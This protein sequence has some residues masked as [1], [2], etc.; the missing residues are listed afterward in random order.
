MNR[1]DYLKNSLVVRHFVEYL[2]R[3]FGGTQRIDFTYRFHHFHAPAD[4]DERFGLEGT[5]P[6]LEDLFD[7]YYWNRAYYAENADKLCNIQRR[8]RRALEGDSVVPALVREAVADVMD[9]GLGRG[10]RAAEANKAWAEQ[11]GNQLASLLHAGKKALESDDPDFTVFGRVR[12]NAGYTKVFSL[13]ADGIIIY[14]SRVGA[15]LCWLVRCFLK[16]AGRAGPVPNELA[17]LWAPG[18]SAQNRNPCG[19]GYHFGRLSDD[20]AWAR[21]NASASWLLE[22]ARKASGAAWCAGSDGLRNVE[23]A[24]FMLGYALPGGTESPPPASVSLTATRAR[25]RRMNG[26]PVELARNR[27]QY[28]YAPGS[29]DVEEL[30]EW[31]KSSGRG[32]VIIGGVNKRF[33]EHQ[34]PDSLDY[35]LRARSSR[36]DVRQ[37]TIAVVARI[38]ATGRFRRERQHWPD[39][40]RPRDALVLTMEGR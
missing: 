37:A 6:L 23:C 30:E 25:E 20:M 40:R 9:W 34:R 14:D 12:M 11:Q 38:T 21:A 4:F 10:S 15:A 7:R 17:F 26:S 32:Y 22:A 31:V 27:I 28:E 1:N 19:D 5:A 2:S 33:V 18:K 16:A 13:L 8:L 29:F 24:L 39:E 35:W 36:P 3:V